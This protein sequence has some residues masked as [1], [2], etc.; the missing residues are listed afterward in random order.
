LVR[1]SRFFIRSFTQ[2]TYEVPS[3][4][5]LSKMTEAAPIQ[6]TTPEVPSLP[7][8]FAVKLTDDLQEHLDKFYADGLT[9][10][11]TLNILYCLIFPIYASKCIFPNFSLFHF[12]RY[13]ATSIAGSTLG[14]CANQYTYSWC[15][16]VS[17]TEI[18]IWH[19]YFRWPSHE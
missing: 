7:M 18:S 4:F 15:F 10:T 17:C 14:M 16:S 2:F 1:L 13:C 12:S 19:R 11:I 9:P 3:R 6:I 5:R 8:G